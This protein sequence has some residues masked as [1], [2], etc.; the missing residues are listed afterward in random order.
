MPEKDIIRTPYGKSLWFATQL[1]SI[2]GVIRT[3]LI[4]IE[5]AFSMKKYVFELKQ[6]LE[7]YS[8]GDFGTSGNYGSTKGILFK[9]QLKKMIPRTLTYLLPGLLLSVLLGGCSSKYF[10]YVPI[11]CST[12]SVNP[13]SSITSFHIVLPSVR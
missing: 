7:H 2:S 12:S 13:I 6:K 11:R 9:D 1:P 4:P 5:P 3:N 10:V 8:R